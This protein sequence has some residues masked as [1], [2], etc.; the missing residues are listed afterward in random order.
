MIHCNPACKH[1]TEPFNG[2]LRSGCEAMDPLLPNY[3][4]RGYLLMVN[5]ARMFKKHYENSYSFLFDKG[6]GR[7]VN[8][9]LWETAGAS[10][11]ARFSSQTTRDCT[12]YVRPHDTCSDYCYT[13][14]NDTR[15]VYK[16]ID[17]C[18]GGPRS[19]FFQESLKEE[20]KKLHGD[21]K[22]HFNAE[23]VCF[24]SFPCAD[25]GH[26]NII[27]KQNRFFMGVGRAGDK[28]GA[29]VWAYLKAVRTWEVGRDDQYHKH[30]AYWKKNEDALYRV[31][32]ASHFDLC[33]LKRN[34][35]WSTEGQTIVF[36]ATYAHFD[37]KWG[38]A[39]LH[40]QGQ[41]YLMA[42]RHTTEE[43]P[44]LNGTHFAIFEKDFP[45]PDNCESYYFDIES[46]SGKVYR[47]PEDPKYT[48]VTTGHGCNKNHYYEIAPGNT[49]A[50]YCPGM[51]IS[52]ASNR[53]TMFPTP[54]KIRTPIPPRF[55]N[56]KASVRGDPHFMTWFGVH[57][58]FHGICDLVLLYNPAFR[59]NLGMHIHIR[60]KKTRRWS[61]V[62]AAA[63]QIGRDI[64]EVVGGKVKNSYWFNGSKGRKITA[65]KEKLQIAIAGHPISFKR[66][67]SKLREF[68]IDIGAEQNI[69]FQI[70]NKMLSVHING[71]IDRD[72]D[73][74]LGM[75]GLFET[76]DKIARN[77][78]TNIEDSNLFGLE[79]QV[80]PTD[81]MLFHSIEGPQL[82]DKCK[83]A[84]AIDMRRRLS[85][86]GISTNGA[87]NAC[88]RVPKEDRDLC[89][90]DVI[91]T[92]N[93]DAA[94]PYY[95]NDTQQVQ[96]RAK[97]PMSK[98]R[99]FF[100]INSS[101]VNV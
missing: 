66:V 99:G 7:G 19:L 62:S 63:I 6:C 83:I 22:I 21:R 88:S 47:F 96:I 28:P 15:S 79:W 49:T 11:E 35:W 48:F 17:G 30:L 53:P 61:F 29:H 78:F 50:D 60:A 2:T 52:F 98:T 57:Y 97:S 8:H 81:P 87:D 40:Y 38:N 82:P 4:E 3:H 25:L 10:E 5:Y 65:K 32:V 1:E 80:R 69:N 101:P 84:S 39:T 73:G 43:T 76:G 75:L 23:A 55:A 85:E 51:P 89:I 54:V 16:P 34:C 95:S 59:N 93:K 71:A 9:P 20:Y 12:A 44:A 26:C 36:M 92:N 45:W 86:S 68:K 24:N 70:W 13:Y 77:G 64:L 72:F 18:G 33:H 58:D 74:S 14:A 100:H 41:Q 94:E 46:S 90:F 56:R 37:E 31:P 67:N 27:N 91:A 42:E